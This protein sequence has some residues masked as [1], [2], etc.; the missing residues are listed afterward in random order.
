MNFDNDCFYCVK[1]ARLTNLMIEVCKLDASTLY[2]FKEQT[3]K[4]RC[5][6]AY[7]GHKSE[8]FNLTDEERSKF[9]GD[10]SRVAGALNKAFSPDKI[11]YGAYADTMTHLH[12]HI[13]PKYKGGPSFGGTFEMSPSDKVLLKDEEYNLLISKIK[14]NL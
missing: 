2:L 1:D 10:V 6:V 8:L 11:N 5:V 3:Y 9:M 4:G 14:E 12:F 7:N 13:V